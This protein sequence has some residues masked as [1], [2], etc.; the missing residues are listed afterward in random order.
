MPV[1]TD[2]IEWSPPHP[3]HGKILYYNIKIVHLPNGEENLILGYDRTFASSDVWT[4]EWNV[5]DSFIIKASLRMQLQLSVITFI[6]KLYRMGE[7]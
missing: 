5:T 1:G 7:N 6:R 4:N 3:P 2:I